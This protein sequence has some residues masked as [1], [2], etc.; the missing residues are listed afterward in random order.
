MKS[1]H[2]KSCLIP[3]IIQYTLPESY[4]RGYSWF[5]ID[6]FAIISLP[7]WKKQI[8]NWTFSVH[9]CIKEYRPINP[10]FLGNKDQSR[11]PISSFTIIYFQGAGLCMSIQ[12]KRQ[13]MFALFTKRPKTTKTKTKTIKTTIVST[14]ASNVQKSMNKVANKFRFTNKLLTAPELILNNS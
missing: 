2:G 6:L 4:T 9:K 7:N 5:L 8:I 13:N 11:N 12:N 14:N 3:D 10:V 1:D